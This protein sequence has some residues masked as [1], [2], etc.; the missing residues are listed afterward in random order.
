MPSFVRLYVYLF[1]SFSEDNFPLILHM[2]FFSFFNHS[3]PGLFDFQC[4]MA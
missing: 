4:L 2:A 1:Y 3:E